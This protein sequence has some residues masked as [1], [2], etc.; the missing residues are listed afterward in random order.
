VLA[1]MRRR[2][3]EIVLGMIALCALVEVPLFTFNKK[4][5]PAAE[6]RQMHANDGKLVP[7]LGDV[8]ERWRIYDEF[9]LGER[10]GA[11]L[12]IRDFRGYPALDPI[13]LR[14]Y[15][16]VLDF[17][18]REPAI[19]QDFNVRWVLLKPHFRYA[20][21]TQFPRLP[22]PEFTWRREHT[23]EA[24]HPVPL[25]QWVGQAVV[26]P[27]KKVL[28][29]MRGRVLPDGWRR[30]AVLEPADHTLLPPSAFAWV[31]GGDPT[32]LGPAPAPVEGQLV[33][34]EPDEIRFTIDAPQDGL[35]VLN[36]IMFPGWQVEV[37]GRAATPVRA[38]YLLRAVWVQKGHHTIVWRF[39]PRRWR[40]LV[41]CY[42][43][44]LLVIAGAFVSA[45]VQA[46]RRES[47]PA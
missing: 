7:L 37:D 10:A 2:F 14:R 28:A 32:R 33:S 27:Q 25:I 38:N 22:N 29:T 26:V 40:I 17:S 39:E 4:A 43:L 34:Y 12:R 35:V 21:S 16:E 19:L 5:L 8:Q 47:R 30:V 20:V 18:V 31:T 24:N 9:V 44:A 23:W 15:V 46:R 6:Q 42:V 45:R 36:E 3:S 41:G 13:S 1:A 11:R